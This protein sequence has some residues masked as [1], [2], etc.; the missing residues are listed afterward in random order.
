MFYVRHK[1]ALRPPEFRACS[2]VPE[3]NRKQAAAQNSCI[4]RSPTL[5]VK[6]WKT[7]AFRK[8][9]VRAKMQLFKPLNVSVSER[10]NAA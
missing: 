8:L 7:A 5:E 10:R 6:Y 1:I 9:L 4:K 3:V 2:E